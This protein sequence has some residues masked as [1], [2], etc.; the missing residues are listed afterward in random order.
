MALAFAHA[1]QHLFSASRRCAIPPSRISMKTAM[2]HFLE[3]AR[4]GL[5]SVTLHPL[6]SAA[7][8]AALVVVLLPYLVGVSIAKGIEAEAHRS[9]RYGADLYLQGSQFGR[10]A[11]LPV[12]FVKTLNDDVPGIV[13]VVPRI[14]GE[15]TLGKDRIPAVLIGLPPEHFPVWAECI[16]GELPRSGGPHEFVIGSALARQLNL[17]IDS[18]LL[19]FYR[20][21]K[22]G[23]RISRVVGVFRRD[24]PLWQA[25]LILTTFDSAESIFAHSRQATDVLIWCKEGYQS[26][27]ARLV[28][29]RYSFPSQDGRGVVR[30]R[31]TS[32]EE[33]LALLPRGLLH[34]EGVFNLHFLLA[35][36][37]GILVLLVTSGFGLPERRREI[38]IL[39]ALGWQTDEVLVR[40]MVESVCLSLLGACIALV[41]TWIWLCWFNGIGVA[42]LFISGAAAKPDFIV[43]YR[44]TP[45]PCMLAFI[46]ALAIV[47]TGTLFSV[48]RAATV[49]PREALR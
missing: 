36:V 1:T 43:P 39:K 27:V 30:V 37:V 26:E 41:G 9:A 28:V 21:D 13:R 8:V 10:P 18:M 25:H 29:N 35:F 33:L 47:L 2:G 22:Q 34:R 23:E 11:P 32:R 31:V 6:R 15:V 16:D 38:G 19:P 14:I 17:K 45:I 3:I 46:L 48:W 40:G 4:T 44:L 5:A 12:E 7:A 20:N 42:G 24:A 49:P